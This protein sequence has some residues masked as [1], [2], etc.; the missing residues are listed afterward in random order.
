[1]LASGG[2]SGRIAAAQKP[3]FS[4]LENMTIAENTNLP[5]PDTTDPASPRDLA[6]MAMSAVAIRVLVLVLCAAVYHKPFVWFAHISDGPSYLAYARA[7]LGDSSAMTEYDRRVFVGYPLLIAGV[8]L[9]GVPLVWA[10]YGIDWVS[11]A[12]A[13]VVS[14]ILTRNRRLGWAM[15]CLTPHFL[16]YSSIAM[17]EAPLLALDL[18]GILLALWAID[19]E[20]PD[21]RRWLYPLLGGL[22]LGYAGVVRPFACFAVAGV[23]AHALLRRNWRA[24]AIVAVASAGVVALAGIGL[25]L[26]TGDALHNVKVYRD[27]PQ[28]YDGEMFTY[29]FKSLIHQTLAGGVTPFKAAYIWSYVALNL[30]AVALLARRWFKQRDPQL[31]N[32]LYFIWLTGNTV[33]ILCIGSRW[34][35]HAFH[36]FSGWALPAELVCFMPI[37]PRRVWIWL[38]VA[39]AS[40]VIAVGSMMRNRVGFG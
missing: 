17:T 28:A 11:S 23:M 31:H 8:H 7:I 24:A 26:A 19:R 12:V 1:M 36:R 27:N 14:A 34:G 15:V 6:M 29:P 32:G 20:L 2:K 13:A 3:A 9:L 33:A 18:G 22:L 35:F 4:T 39:A 25:Q 5:K 38:L 30:A 10:A 40:V 37:L 21:R 16:L